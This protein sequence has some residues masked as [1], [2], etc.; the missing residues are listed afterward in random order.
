MYRST[1][2]Q[3]WTILCNRNIRVRGYFIRPIIWSYRPTANHEPA[4]I[5]EYKFINHFTAE[6]L[7]YF[8]FIVRKNVNTQPILSM[9][10][11]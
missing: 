9:L 10:Q 3:H 11:K 7:C 1:V 4:N 5:F 8:Y 2:R 6:H